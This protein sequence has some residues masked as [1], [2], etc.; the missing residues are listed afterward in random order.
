MA[1]HADILSQ[2]A[3]ENSRHLGAGNIIERSDTTIGIAVDIGE[4]IIAVQPRRS[5]GCRPA[6]IHRPVFIHADGVQL[7]CQLRLTIP[8]GKGVALPQ[9]RFIKYHDCPRRIPLA[10]VGGSAIGLIVKRVARGTAATAGA[11]SAGACAAGW[12]A[13]NDV[14]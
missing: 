6:G 2:Q 1:L 3:V 13:E 9:G 5:G 4:V 10:G 11:S 8:A 12:L 14:G 7:C